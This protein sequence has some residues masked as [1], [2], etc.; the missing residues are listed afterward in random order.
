MHKKIGELLIEKGFVNDE[1]IRF[2]L[3]EQESTGERVG[4]ILVRLGIVT[5]TEV[6]TVLAEQS[7]KC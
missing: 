6:A 4:D 2:A 3:K 5:D 7:K 1:Y